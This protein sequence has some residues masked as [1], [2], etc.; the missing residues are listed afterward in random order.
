M[1]CHNDNVIGRVSEVAVRRARLVLGLVT[2]F[3]GHTTLVSLPIH[4]SQLSLLPSAEWENEYRPKGNEV[5]RLASKARWF[6]PRVNKRVG[7]R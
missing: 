6:I 3:D 5:L 1:A 7:G 4:P 2:V